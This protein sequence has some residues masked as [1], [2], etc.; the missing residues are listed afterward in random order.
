MMRDLW[1]VA[2]HGSFFLGTPLAPLEWGRRDR[3]EFLEAV[4]S[5]THPIRRGLSGLMERSLDKKAH[6]AAYRS[7]LSSAFLSPDDSR[8]DAIERVK[9]RNRGFFD[10]LFS[11]AGLEERTYRSQIELVASRKAGGFRPADRGAL[12]LE[13]RDHF[14]FCL[15]FVDEPLA[16]EPKEHRRYH[17]VLW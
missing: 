5:L 17:Y 10:D 16:R 13:W 9:A 1:F 15:D 2:G 8:G 7:Q 11:L 3:G 14:S 6:F 4:E 12:K